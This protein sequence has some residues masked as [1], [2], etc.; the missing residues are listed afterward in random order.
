MFRLGV[1]E[2]V[3]LHAVEGLPRKQNQSAVLTIQIYVFADRPVRLVDEAILVR[4][5][6]TPTIRQNKTN[7]LKII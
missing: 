2:Y 7:H 1:E 6:V 5:T 4:L 3:V